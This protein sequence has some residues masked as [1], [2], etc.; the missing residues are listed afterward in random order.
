MASVSARNLL[1]SSPDAT[2]SVT[3]LDCADVAVHGRW[4]LTLHCDTELTTS[5]ARTGTVLPSITVLLLDAQSTI[6]SWVRRSMLFHR[7]STDSRRY[8]RPE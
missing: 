6:T 5:P 7:Y 3:S 8:G 1:T 2:D 4:R